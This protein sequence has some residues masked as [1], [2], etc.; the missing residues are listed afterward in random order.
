MVC[1]VTVSYAK[2]VEQL[3]NRLVRQ[4]GDKIDSIVL[5]GSVAKNT[6]NEESDIDILVVARDDEIG[7]YDKISKIRTQVDLENNTLTALMYVTC[8]ELEHFAK[9]GSPFMKSV[10]EEGVILYDRGVFKKLRGSMLGKS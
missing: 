7:L 9:L 2:A 6:A 1:A 8:E 3:R 10:S 5:Y 4:L